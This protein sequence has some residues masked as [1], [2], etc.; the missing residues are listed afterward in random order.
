ME[1]IFL[2]NLK[3]LH[4]AGN[5]LKMDERILTV[6]MG[7]IMENTLD[8]TFNMKDFLNNSQNYSKEV[9]FSAVKFVSQSVQ[10]IDIKG[11][12]WAITE[13]K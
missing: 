8:H 10:L 12:N 2:E 7:E 6:L 9:L 4:E 13:R 3:F 11:I 5:P 1:S